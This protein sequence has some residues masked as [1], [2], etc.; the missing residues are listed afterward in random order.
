MS[1]FSA[2]PAAD[3]PSHHHPKCRSCNT[4]YLDV[5]ALRDHL[6]DVHILTQRL[7]LHHAPVH[8]NQNSDED[9]A[10][11]GEILGRARLD[12]IMSCH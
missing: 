9:E 3:A 8:T 10:E 12:T 4:R 5:V 2:S 1:Y 6:V 11:G 7:P